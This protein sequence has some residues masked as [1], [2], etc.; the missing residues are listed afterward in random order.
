[1]TS[2]TLEIGEVELSPG[3]LRDSMCLTSGSNSTVTVRVVPAPMFTL[4][5]TEALNSGTAQ[6]WHPRRQ[7]GAFADEPQSVKRPTSNDVVPSFEALRRTTLSNV[8]ISFHVDEILEPSPG[9]FVVAAPKRRLLK[10]TILCV[11]KS[12]LVKRPPHVVVSDTDVD[13]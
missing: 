5:G 2:C 1:M 12:G 4:S 8:L 3:E 10:R 9:I 7:T 13:E 6:R 11:P